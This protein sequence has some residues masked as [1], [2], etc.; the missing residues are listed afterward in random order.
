MTEAPAG[1]GGIAPRAPEILVL[2]GTN[3]AGKSSVAGAAV[4]ARGGEYFNPD[5]A[6]RRILEARPGASAEQA[7]I[8]AWLQG[9]RLLER[10]IAE[11]LD[12][13][14]ETTLGGSTITRL[15]RFAIEDGFEVRIWFVGL[16]SPELHI[17]R[18]R[19]RVAAG[20]HDIPEEK[21]RSRYDDS[22][23]N[24]IDLM[25]GLAELYLYDNSFEADPKR[26]LAP[27]PR[28]LLHAVRGAV[29]ALCDLATAPSWAKPILACAL[30]R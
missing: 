24:L 14:F 12:Y 4:R 20:G 1:G 26:G 18:V 29:V 17:A 13:A 2:A 9:K 22:R 11:R 5:E 6:T 19:G 27:R 23:S 21:I 15:L 25:P 10:A 7:N 3:G 16:A 30:R 28:L 8:D